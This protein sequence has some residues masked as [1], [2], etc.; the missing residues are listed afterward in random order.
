MLVKLLL[1]S[2][3]QRQLKKLCKYIICFYMNHITFQVVNK[4]KYQ[5]KPTCQSFYGVIYLTVFQRSC[6]IYMLQRG[7]MDALHH[8]EGTDHVI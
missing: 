8:S 7:R 1:Q 2:W 5:I 6:F 3:G 4:T